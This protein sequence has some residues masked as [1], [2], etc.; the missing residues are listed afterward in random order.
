MLVVVDLSVMYRTKITLLNISNLQSHSADYLLFTI[1]SY[2][3]NYLVVIKSEN[4]YVAISLC[5]TVIYTDF[6]L[7]ARKILHV[8]SL[9]ELPVCR[10]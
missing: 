10:T 8:Q 7:K 2:G 1:P 4:S 5:K 3:D 6:I 9:I